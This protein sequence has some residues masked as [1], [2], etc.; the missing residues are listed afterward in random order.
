M[1]SADGSLGDRIES[2]ELEFNLLKTEIR[3][4]LV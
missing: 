3:Q 1:V 4:T 2:L